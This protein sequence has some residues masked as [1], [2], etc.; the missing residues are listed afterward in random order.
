FTHKY[1]FLLRMGGTSII[2]DNHMECKTKFSIDVEFSFSF[3]GKMKNSKKLLD[4]AKRAW[5][6]LRAV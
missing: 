4:I 6:T 5:Y 2:K 3:K 1:L